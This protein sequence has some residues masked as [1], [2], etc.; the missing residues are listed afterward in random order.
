MP[1]LAKSILCLLLFCAL[2]IPAPAKAALVRLLKPEQIDQL[3]DAYKIIDARPVSEWEKG[4]IPEALPLYWEDYTRT[5]GGIDFSRL[6]PEQMAERLGQL[7]I[8]ETTPLVVYGDADSSWGG[9]G[10]VCWLLRDLGHVGAVYLLE[11]GVQAWQ[12][13]HRMLSADNRISPAPATTYRFAL[14]NEI[15]IKTEE[16]LQ[17]RDRLQIVDTRSFFE[18]LRSSI[19]GAVRINWTNFF[20]GKERI[21]ISREQLVE[22]LCKHDIDPEKPVVYYCSGGIRSAY[23]WT[24]HE[25][26]GLKSA[27][28]Y[29]GGME[30]WKMGRVY[31]K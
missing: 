12:K 20:T 24:V 18:W 22:L 15:D 19:P 31:G 27:K 8:D 3:K 9:E 17:S 23:A 16:L 13:H 4:H 26:A 25:L 21:P 2:A 29:E 7:G 1:L 14:R 11:G 28:N 6:E 5:N 30:A 10:W